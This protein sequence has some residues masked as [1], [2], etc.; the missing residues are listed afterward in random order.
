MALDHVIMQPILH[1]SA[2]FVYWKNDEP[3]KP[4]NLFSNLLSI[5]KI[6]QIHMYA[7]HAWPN[8]LA[9]A[10]WLVM[11][12]I[13][14]AW[15]YLTFCSQHNICNTNVNVNVVMGG[16]SAMCNFGLNTNLVVKDAFSTVST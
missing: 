5:Q 3:L 6:K 2:A 8:R 15:H 14:F 16:I 1:W 10:L 12:M 11:T 9:N 13:S 7:R 4:D